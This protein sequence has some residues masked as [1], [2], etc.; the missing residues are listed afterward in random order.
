MSSFALMAL[1]AKS[2]RNIDSL[3]LDLSPEINLFVGDNG[4]GKTNILE[5]IA[6]ACSLRPMQSLSNTDLI[7]AGKPDAQ[8]FASFSDHEISIEISHLGKKAKAKGQNITSAQQRAQ[9]HPIVSFIPLE[10]NMLTGSAS[11]RRRA[12][13]QATISLY[14]EHY[15]A[16]KAYEKILLHRN[17]LLKLWPR[18]EKTIASFTNLLIQEGALIIYYRLNTIE[19]LTPY[20][21]TY[22]HDILGAAYEPELEYLSNEKSL[23]S[24]SLLDIKALLT[25]KARS[26][27][28]NEYAR[29]VTLFGPHLDDLVFGLNSFNAKTHASRGQMRALVLS[30]KLAA[31]AAICNIRNTKPI[32]IL[33]D[34]VS[35]LD[36]RKKKNLAQVISRLEVQAFFSATEPSAFD[37]MNINKKIFQVSNGKIIY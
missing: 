18:D 13:D 21:L 17:K 12:L 1:C 22:V 8:I 35:E 16:L 7:Q 36:S 30:F 26:C 6:L 19:A 11:L 2:F 31:I 28:A 4:Q 37:D 33:D 5:A 29:K 27:E 24:Y 25:Q 15:R 10:L 14:F 3:S 23:R 9:I 32:I 20:F 34:I